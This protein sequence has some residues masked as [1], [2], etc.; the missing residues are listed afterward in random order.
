MMP[1]PV[2]TSSSDRKKPRNMGLFSKKQGKTNP[3][4]TS[5]ADMAIIRYDAEIARKANGNI[6]M[7]CVDQLCD[8]RDGKVVRAQADGGLSTLDAVSLVWLIM[9]GAMLID[10]GIIGGGL[11][12]HSLGSYVAFG[13]LGALA[14]ASVLSPRGTVEMISH[15][16]ED[17]LHPHE[18]ADDDMS[19]K[20]DADTHREGHEMR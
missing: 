6:L 14:F 13:L 10:N 15:A 17:C 3:Q 1:M 19:E 2:M 7:Q 11:S 12:T 16:I 20:G 4:A 9:S 5:P 18:K 8:L